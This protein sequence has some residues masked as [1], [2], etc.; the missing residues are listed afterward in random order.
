VAF[1][2][3]WYHDLDHQAVA[4]TF[5]GGSTHRLKSY[6]C[7][8]QHFPLKIA[9]G[10]ETELTHTF[11]RLVAECIKPKLRKQQGNAWISDKTWALVGQRMALR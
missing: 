11:S 7:N 5:L 4:A 8:R 3:P 10:E 9:Q 6:Q 1:C 2:L